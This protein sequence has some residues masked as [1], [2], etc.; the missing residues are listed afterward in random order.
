[1]K[2]NKLE[3][4]KFNI[5]IK[6]S[7]LWTSVTLCYLYGDYFELY[8]PKKVGGLVSGVN[9]LDSPLKLFIASLLLAIPAVMV[10]LSIVLK[11]SLNRWLNI[12]FGIFFTIFVALVGVSSIS[13]WR[14]F[15]VFLAIIEVLITSTIVAYAWNWPRRKNQSL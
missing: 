4:F 5:K 9:M 15:Y 11:P 2:V 13:P 10:F 7:A 12:V 6:L 14:A 8:V 3:D 1:M